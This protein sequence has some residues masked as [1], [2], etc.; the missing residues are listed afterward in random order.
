MHA[1]NALSTR[2]ATPFFQK[3]T[4]SFTYPHI[5]PHALLRGTFISI[6]TML[7]HLSKEKLSHTAQTGGGSK[8]RRH[9]GIPLLLFTNWKSDLLCLRL[10][11]HL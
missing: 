7:L 1:L 5:S 4:P 10:F 6:Q 9:A 3:M 8:A 2:A 11:S